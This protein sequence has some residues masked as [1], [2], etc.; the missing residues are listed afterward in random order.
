[1]RATTRGSGGRG[2]RDRA[3]RR[4]ARGSG[5]RGA[6]A[7]CSRSFRFARVAA[8]RSRGTGELTREQTVVS[9]ERCRLVFVDWTGAASRRG[10]F[11][12]GSFRGF[13]TLAASPLARARTHVRPR[14]TPPPP[15]L[16]HPRPPPP[17][18]A[19]GSAL[20]SRHT[21][22]S[23]SSTASV[24][25]PPAGR[26][27]GGGGGRGFGGRSPGGRGGFGGRGGRGGR[28]G[29]D[30]GPPDTVVGARRRRVASVVGR[31]ARVAIVSRPVRRASRSQ[32]D[33]GFS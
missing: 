17:P 1:M 7:R 24:M 18:P 30:E 2:R 10:F 20:E 26:G 16:P 22:S 29:F 27:F 25:R 19:R 23:S 13:S 8:G 32:F 4:R 28:G 31:S 9:I 15:P 11:G 21:A 12:R 5:A 6:R 14:S 33:P 3:T